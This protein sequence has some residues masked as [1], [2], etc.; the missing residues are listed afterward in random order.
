MNYNNYELHKGWKESDFANF[1]NAEAAYFNAELLALGY[2]SKRTL[3]VLDIGFGNG[4]FMGWC[5]QQGHYVIG[6]ELNEKLV[7]RAVNHGFIACNSLDEIINSNKAEF[8]LIVAF[9]VLEHIE[10]ENIQL[11]LTNL[12]PLINHNSRLLFLFP[13]GDNPFAI[14]LQNGDITHRTAIGSYMLRQIAALSG[15]EVVSLKRSETPINSVNIKRKIMILAGLPVRY[16][17]G[18]LVRFIFMGGARVEFS[19]N[20][21]AILKKA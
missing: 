1:S 4:Q 12:H 14:Y 11:F 2:K 18:I 20:L 19:A 16:I 5:K 13:N 3:R 9:S 6:L 7:Q 21:V 17:F 8:D 15:Y 10:K